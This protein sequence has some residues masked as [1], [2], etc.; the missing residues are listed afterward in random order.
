MSFIYKYTLLGGRVVDHASDSF[1][2]S[3][4]F[5]PLLVGQVEP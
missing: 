1:V 5:H 3:F 4:V 2:E